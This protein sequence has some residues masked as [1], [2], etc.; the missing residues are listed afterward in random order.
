MVFKKTLVTTGKK[1]VC[2]HASNI[3]IK[4]HT[5]NNTTTTQERA[6]EQKRGTDRGGEE[7]ERVREDYRRHKNEGGGVKNTTNGFPQTKCKFYTL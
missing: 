7:R 1:Q 4:I 6:S 3:Q 2:E 5:I